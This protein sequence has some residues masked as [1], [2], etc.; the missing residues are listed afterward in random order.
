MRFDQWLAHMWKHHLRSFHAQHFGDS[1][2]P[3][4]LFVSHEAF[5]PGHTE[6]HDGEEEEEEEGDDG[7]GY[8]EDGT[9][10]TLTDEQIAMFRHS[11][12]QKLLRE[13]VLEREQKDA[14]REC[15]VAIAKAAE[16]ARPTSGRI[17]SSDEDADSG[18][19][20][21]KWEHFIDDSEENPENLTHRRLAR[22]LDELRP[23]DVELTYGDEE[24][25]YPAISLPQEAMASIKAAA[26]KQKPPAFQWP[27]LGSDT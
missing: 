10:R 16:T 15:E 8:Y 17:Q 6:Y 21:R 3:T 26:Q 11:E 22:E 13:R 27:V 24:E 7:L 5:E 20:K 23:V 19:T 1:P 14:D 2:A 4:Q 12:I 18:Q 25:E 9:K